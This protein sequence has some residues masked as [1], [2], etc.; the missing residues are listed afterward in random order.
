MPCHPRDAPQM[1]S[2]DAR[3][4]QPDAHPR[5]QAERAVVH[6]PRPRPLLLRGLLCEA[7]VGTAATSLFF[8]GGTTVNV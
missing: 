4:L 5:G 2:D 3:L 7:H 6:G 1:E 8:R